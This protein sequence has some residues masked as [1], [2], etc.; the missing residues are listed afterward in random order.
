[1][2]KTLKNLLGVLLILIIAL[3]VI[4]CSGKK[5]DASVTGF[6][7]AIKKSDFQTAS[8][9]ANKN[10]AKEDFKFG[11]TNEENLVKALFAK[12]NYEIISSTVNGKNATVKTKITVP[13]LEKIYTKIVSDLIANLL[14]EK[15]KPTDD[16]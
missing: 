4:G 5:P 10:G 11:D 7:D 2:L 6:L 3:S 16:R 15:T 1:M 12:M 9:F 13:D 14:K 8:T